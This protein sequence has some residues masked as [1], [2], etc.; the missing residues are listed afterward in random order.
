MKSSVQQLIKKMETPQT[1]TPTI[2]YTPLVPPV[3]P[4][5]RATPEQS[6]LIQS[7]LFPKQIDE[8]KKIL[9][10]T[11]NAFNDYYNKTQDQLNNYNATVELSSNLFRENIGLQTD[12]LKL[13]KQMSELDKQISG[14]KEDLSNADLDLDDC[15]KSEKKLI[16]EKESLNQ[17]LDDATKG[18]AQCERSKAKLEETI[19]M[20][21]SKLQQLLGLQS[22]PQM[23]GGK[24]KAY[25]LN[26]RIL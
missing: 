12:K 18:I 25:K 13:N 1:Q 24:M 5:V 10:E 8:C 4:V 26:L 15:E 14:L 19:N 20:M 21:Q 3:A 7:S 2:Q 23:G 16:E 6:R 22:N 17:K 11:R 9:E